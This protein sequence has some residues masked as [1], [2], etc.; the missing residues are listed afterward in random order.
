FKVLPD[1][2]G[3]DNCDGCCA[4]PACFRGINGRAC[5]SGGKVCDDC[6]PDGVC[7]ASGECTV[8][9]ALCTDQSCAGCCIGAI[10]AVGSQD[11]ACG[12]MGANCINCTLVGERCRSGS[13]G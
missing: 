2:C 1:H 9:H 11:V 3:P 10:C 13:C 8:S 4:G 5:G 12:V 6:Y 7:L